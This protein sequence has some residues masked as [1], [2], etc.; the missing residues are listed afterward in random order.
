MPSLWNAGLTPEENKVYHQMHRNRDRAAEQVP[1]EFR[2]FF[3][4]TLFPSRELRKFVKF[5]FREEGVK[6]NPRGFLEDCLAARFIID[7]FG[8]KL[9]FQY[10]INPDAYLDI[11]M[12]SIEL[13]SPQPLD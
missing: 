1:P 12:D 4:R 10:G 2:G 5:T 9:V 8:A 3:K 13:P 7:D 11:F 6:G